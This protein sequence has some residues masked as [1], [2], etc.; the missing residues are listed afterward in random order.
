MRYSLEEDFRNN[1]QNL[2][3]NEIGKLSIIEIYTLEEILR[4]GNKGIFN[5]FIESKGTYTESQAVDL[6]NGFISLLNEDVNFKNYKIEQFQNSPETLSALEMFIFELIIPTENKETENDKETKSDKKE[7]K[8]EYD[9]FNPI[10]YSTDGRIRETLE[11]LFLGEFIHK[12]LELPNMKHIRDRQIEKGRI[13]NIDKPFV[14]SKVQE[15]VL[16][17]VYMAQ[18]K[19]VIDNRYVKVKMAIL[20]GKGEEAFKEYVQYNTNISSS[21]VL[22]KEKE[23]TPEDM[24]E[25]FKDIIN[26]KKS[27]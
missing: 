26:Q 12:I 23:L 20:L 3:D 8:L 10:L 22:G 1:I 7:E 14:I 17:E 27:R 9:P 11:S 15:A 2:Y 18:F 5:K 19:Q 4:Y 21:E 16:S 13:A 25:Y 24:Y 6:F